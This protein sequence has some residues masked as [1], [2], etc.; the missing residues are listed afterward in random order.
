MESEQ[1]ENQGWKEKGINNGGGKKGVGARWV[2]GGWAKYHHKPVPICDRVDKQEP[3]PRAHVLLSHGAEFLLTSRVQYCKAEKERKTSN[4]Q[5]V[6]QL[7]HNTFI[8]KQS[9]HSITVHHSC[10]EMAL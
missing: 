2:G 7:M 10:P 3:F 9:T 5:Q 6:E 4:K 8:N 1:V